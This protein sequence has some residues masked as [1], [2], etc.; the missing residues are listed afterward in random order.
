[1]STFHFKLTVTARPDVSAEH[2]AAMLEYALQKFLAEH[3]Y[4]IDATSVQVALTRK[5]KAS[6][7]PHS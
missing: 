3:D 4:G 1:M 2:H 5:R 7:E 6:D